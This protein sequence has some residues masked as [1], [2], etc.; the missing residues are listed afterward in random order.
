MDK[1]YLSD[2]DNIKFSDMDS[3]DK[4]EFLS[5][6]EDY[7]IEYRDTLQFNGDTFGME[8]EYEGIPYTEVI[9]DISYFTGWESV[10][11]KGFQIG[12]ELVSPVLIDNP[13]NWQDIKEVLYLIKNT[14]G[15][16]ANGGAHVHVGAH[17]LEKYDNLIKFLLLYIDYENILYRFGYMDRLNPRKTLISAAAPL[18]IELADDMEDIMSMNTV[19]SINK[20]YERFYGVNFRNLS[21]LKNKKEKNTIEFRFGNC[22]FDNVIWQNYINACVKLLEA[23]KKDLDLE[24]LL[25]FM[26]RIKDNQNNYYHFD[27]LDI[28]K[29]MDFCDIIFDN[30]L[31]KTN[32]MKQYIKDG[33]ETVDSSQDTYSRKFTRAI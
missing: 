25:Y 30:A 6:L 23:S 28:K 29:A 9:D 20:R 22:T 24:R 15:T 10:E 31:D 5:S 14:Q 16:L 27:Q 3:T 7:V 4:A 33:R 12:G 19:K 8:I 1:I 26:Y 21:S 2:I 17:C 32:F 18:S 11:E 13:L